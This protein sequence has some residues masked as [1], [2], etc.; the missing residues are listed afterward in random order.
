MSCR[1]LPDIEILKELYFNQKMSYT[2]IA[3]LCN[4]SSARVENM[5][6]RYR[7]KALDIEVL[8]KLYFDKKMSFIEIASE[9]KVDPSTVRRIFQR[10]GIKARSSP[11]ACSLRGHSLNLTPEIIDFL[12]GLL[13]GDGCITYVVGRTT[14]KKSWLYVHT[15][16]NR[17]YIRWLKRALNKLGIS[18]LLPRSGAR[19]CWCLS[20]LCYEALMKIREEWYPNGKKRIPD[21]KISP[22]VLFNYYIGDGHLENGNKKS[23]GIT[24]AECDPEKTKITKQMEDIG[25]HNSSCK[26]CIYIRKSGQEKFFQYICEIPYFIPKCYYYKFPKEYIVYNRVWALIEKSKSLSMKKPE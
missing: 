14:G 20:S 13:L 6:N 2:E 15:D 1:K 8:K 7:A 3:R 22:I 19:N 17:S 10:K 23:R 9:Y 21:L 4:C 12:N 5:L 16:K 26:N 25:I 18:S 24:I 11:E